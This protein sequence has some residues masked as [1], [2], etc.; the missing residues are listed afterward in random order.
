[1]QR[2][3]NP[4]VLAGV[5]ATLA[6]TIGCSQRPINFDDR[7]EYTHIKTFDGV[8]DIG[9]GVAHADVFVLD[10]RYEDGFL[11]DVIGTNLIEVITK[12]GPARFRWPDGRSFFGGWCE[13][14]DLDRDGASEFVLLSGSRAR[15]VSYRGG[16]FRFRPREDE[17]TGYDGL[18]LADYDAD[19]RLDFVDGGPAILDVRAPTKATPLLTARWDSQRGFFR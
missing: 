15:V 2:L 10:R 16:S 13:I 18:R 12:T 9:D 11:G 17:L 19:G 1:M 4:P 7:N 3:W 14:V 8:L 5:L 6:W